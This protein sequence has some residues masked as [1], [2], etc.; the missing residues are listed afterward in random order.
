MSSKL[1]VLAPI[2]RAVR[3]FF[4]SDLQLQREEGKVKI[5]FSDPAATPGTSSSRRKPADLAADKER[6]DLQRMQASLT[7]LLDRAPDS[8][9]T[10]RHLEFIEY[11]LQKKGLRA[12]QKVPYDALQRAL[13]QFEGVVTNWSD[14]GLACLRSKMAV[15]LIDREPDGPDSEGELLPPDSVIDAAPLAHPEPLEG[16]DAEDAEAALRAVYGAVALPGL[17]LDDPVPAHE[18]PPLQVEMQGE[19]S[20]PSARTLTKAQKQAM[21]QDAPDRVEIKFRELQS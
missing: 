7:A 11:A 1:S 9:K 21:R 10:L 3:A 13:E 19:L 14:E 18:S 6:Q 4:K 17:S 16:E 15:A 5:V 8:R 12:L 20:S 2:G